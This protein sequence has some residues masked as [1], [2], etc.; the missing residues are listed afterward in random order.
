MVSFL[1]NEDGP[2]AVEYAVMLALIVV[3]CITAI[4][5]LGYWDWGRRLP[6]L[7]FASFLT[8][9]YGV[10][11]FDLVVLLPALVQL[12]VRLPSAP[13]PTLALAVAWHLAMNLLALAQLLG[14]AAPG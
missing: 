6:A 2:T 14:G 1:K 7:L 8:A 4:T 3:V 11:P 13:R 10:W 9:A 5:T 12:A